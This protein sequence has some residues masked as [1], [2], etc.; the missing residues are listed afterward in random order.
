MK[1]DQQYVIYANVKQQNKFY[2]TYINKQVSIECI[3]NLLSFVRVEI[4]ESEL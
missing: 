3:E 1:Y 2:E 4:I